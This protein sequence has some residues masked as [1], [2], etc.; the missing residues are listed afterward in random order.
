MKIQNSGE[1]GKVTCF[2]C[3]GETL[4]VGTENGFV[5]VWNIDD[6]RA[7]FLVAATKTEI[8]KIVVTKNRIV[9]V[10]SC[11]VHVFSSLPDCSFIFRKKLDNIRNCRILVSVS[12][13]VGEEKMALASQDSG[14]LNILSLSTGL[15]EQKNFLE[16]T[17]TTVK[18][19]FL[20]N[21]N[22]FDRIFCVTKSTSSELGMTIFDI[23]SES[24]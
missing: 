10:D 15:T 17:G 5:I 2:N 7:G 16:E 1:V 21:P 8:E 11:S 22:H 19:A 12:W 18:I 23:K 14:S 13:H 3:D 9:V 6:D 24:F 20:K 4:C